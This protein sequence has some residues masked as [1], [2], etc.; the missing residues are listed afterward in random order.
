[1]PDFTEFPVLDSELRDEQTD[2]RTILT[3]HGYLEPYID[4]MD[5]WCAMPVR[6]THNPNNGVGIEIGPYTL[7]D[8]SDIGVLRAALRSYDTAISGRTLR[9]IK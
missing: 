5:D 9:R 3:D 6:V 4:D 2:G 8:P 7:D 1:M